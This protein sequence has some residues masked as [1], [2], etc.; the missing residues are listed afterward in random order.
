MVDK[1]FHRLFQMAIFCYKNRV[2]GKK[3]RVKYKFTKYRGAISPKVFSKLAY[4]A[5]WVQ[6]YF[7]VH[8][9]KTRRRSK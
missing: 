8:K 4:L 3:E 2:I 7:F 1:I 6:K 9:M 5:I